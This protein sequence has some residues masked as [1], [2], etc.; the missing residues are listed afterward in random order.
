MAMATIVIGFAQAYADAGISSAIIHRQDTTSEQ[1]SSLYWL[2]ILAG[3]VVF[4]LLWLLTPFIAGLFDEPQLTPLL[5]T[6][7]VIFLILPL[8]RQFEVLLQKE[9]KF[10]LLA[11]QE[12][13]AAVFSAVLAIGC[14]LAGLGVWSL[15]VGQLTLVSVRTIMLFW[16]GIRIH[17]PS[18]HFC[19]EDLQGY[20][21]FGVYQIG[22]RSINFLTQRMDQLIVGGLLGAQ[23]LGYYSF[24]FNLV[25]QPQSRIN[26]I[27]TKVAF[28]AFAKAQDDVPRL[29]RGYLA[30]LKMLTVINTPLLIGMAVLAPMFIPLVF[31]DQWLPSVVLV[32]LAAIVSLMRSTGNPVG[33]LLLAKGRADLGFRWNLGLLL[34]SSPIIYVAA[35]WG[36]VISVAIAWVLLQ[37]SL[38]LPAYIWLI[39]PLVGPCGKSYCMAVAGPT[40][41]ALI[42][43]TAVWLGQIFLPPS[44]PSL[45]VLVMMGG[46]VYLLLSLLAQRT[47]VVELGD[48]VLGRRNP[49]RFGKVGVR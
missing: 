10:N 6:V 21:Q 5:R 31:G 40:A 47:V 9:L 44:W 24:A 43:G 18:A 32:Q 3:V 42:M 35:L 15:V 12:I 7:S 38:Q 17:R 19:F 37:A 29:Q 33:S 41:L 23:A 48:L 26:P 34:F 4:A 16:V 2:N 11:R 49:L 28:P 14:A 27:V 25:S 20:W 13:I 8:G 1:L 36:N 45:F 22:E 30:V 46:A 39:R